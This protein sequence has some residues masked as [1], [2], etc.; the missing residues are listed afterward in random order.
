MSLLNEL[1]D[2]IDPKC[3]LKDARDARKDVEEVWE[4][5]VSLDYDLP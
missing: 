1:V 4:D 2:V 5:L 3:T